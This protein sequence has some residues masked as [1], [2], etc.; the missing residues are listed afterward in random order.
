ME[1]LGT[2]LSLTIGVLGILLKK[3]IFKII[4]NLSD[5][6]LY[7]IIPAFCA[8]LI[9]LV[10][11]QGF[12]DTLTDKA[13]FLIMDLPLIIVFCSILF[14]LYR[15]SNNEES[16]K[17]IV[18][19]AIAF[20]FGYALGGALWNL[21]STQELIQPVVNATLNLFRPQPNVIIMPTQH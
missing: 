3:D 7:I 4:K 12:I 2:Y 15:I 21:T 6:I 1:N 18:I 13:A 8:C 20:L 9:K 19:T 11:V 5:N 14:Y 10:V 16:K 17:K